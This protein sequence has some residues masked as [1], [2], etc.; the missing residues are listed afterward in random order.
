MTLY[1]QQLSEKRK[2]FPWFDKNSI[3]VF[4]LGGAFINKFFVV[5]IF[6]AVSH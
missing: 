3:H 6:K 4:G 1:S 5:Q 2:N